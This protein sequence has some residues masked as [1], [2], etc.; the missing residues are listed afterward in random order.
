VKYDL[1]T[2]T[3]YSAD[4]TLEPS[5]LVKIAIKQGLDGIAVTD[6]N[7]IRGGLCAK[8][9]ETPDFHV[10]VGSEISTERGEIIGLFLSEE[11]ITHDFREVISEIRNQNGIVILPHPFD[12]LRHSALFPGDSDA[13]L[14]DAVE[15]FNSRCLLQRDNETARVYAN[16]CHVSMTAGSDAHF[17]NEIGNAGVITH[18]ENLMSAI[19]QNSLELYGR[20]TRFMNPFM[21]KW[22]K[23]WREY[24]PKN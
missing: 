20:K 16:R 13:C 7:T 24:S 2:H 14:I 5:V 18:D 21:T 9:Y 22:L 23:L 10:I 15:G 17:R 6:H 8:E 19:R 1:H 12:N 3:K 4:G 11:I